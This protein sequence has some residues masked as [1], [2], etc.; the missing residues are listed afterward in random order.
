MLFQLADLRFGEHAAVAHQ[1][2]P[3]QTKAGTELFN[4]VRDGC[5]IARIA[6]INIHRDWA[7]FGVGEQTVNDN[8]QPLLAIA[9]VAQAGQ[10][11]GVTFVIAAADVIENQ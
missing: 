10:R 8:R 3:R 5:R 2:Y 11:A 4:L 7:A 9:I 6:G 1:N